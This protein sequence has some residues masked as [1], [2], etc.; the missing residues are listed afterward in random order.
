VGPLSLLRAALRRGRLPDGPLA[1][2]ER[3]IALP[4]PATNAYAA[5]LGVA[6]D[7]PPLT[8]L[9]P[10]AQ[11]AHLDLLIDPAVDVPVVGMV[12]AGNII[13]RVGDLPERPEVTLRLVEI[14]P[15][16]G[17]R[18]VRVDTLVHAQHGVAAAMRSTY[19][20]RGRASAGP[21][22]PPEPT[23]PLPDRAAERAWAASAGRA[24]ARVSGDYNPIHLAAP[25][26]RLLGQRGTVL[27]G[28][29]VAAAAWVDDG[30]RACSQEI[31]FRRPV[32]L[33]GRTTTERDPA[34][35]AFRV[36]APDGTLHALGRHGNADVAAAL[37][38]E[39]AP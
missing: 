2:V 8:W 17:R 32:L 5:W 33:P 24:Y 20:F 31:T 22:R 25:L 35:G 9:Y 15:I 37:L 23:D 39:I 3:A 27:H 1:P 11:G 34:T 38:A 21:K 19:L 29:A 13:A 12:H 6:A 16:A 14:D 28:L 10:W 18:A 7:P 36:V 4:E 26:A 30:A